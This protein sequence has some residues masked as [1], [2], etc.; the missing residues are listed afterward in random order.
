M[1]AVNFNIVGADIEYIVHEGNPLE[2]IMKAA[3]SKDADLIVVGKKKTKD[4]G[5]SHDKL[6]TSFLLRYFDCY[7]NFKNRY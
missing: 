3:K 2:E 4:K 1:N 7:R 5:V 6:A